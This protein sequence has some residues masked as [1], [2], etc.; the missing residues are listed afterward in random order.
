LTQSNGDFRVENIPA[1]GQYKLVISAIGFKEISRPFAFVDMK[2]VQAMRTSGQ[3]MSALLGQLDKDLGNIK[4]SIDQQILGNVTVTTNKPLVQLGIDRKI[5][6]VEKDLSAAGG[7]ATDIMRNVPSVNVD[8]DGNLTLR[9][10]T[11]QIFVDGRP[12]TLTLD[13]IP[14]DQIASVEV[15]TNP[16]AKFDASGGTAGI[17]NIVLKKARRVGYSGNVRAGIDMR[18]RVNVGGDINVRQ[19]KINVFANANFGQRK[20]ISDGTTD[21]STF[22]GN[23]TTDLH[24]VDRNINEGFFAFGRAGFDYFIDNRNTITISGV[25]VRGKF[26]GDVTSN[27]FVDT[28]FVSGDKTSF[29]NRYSTSEGIFRNLGGAVSFLHNFP[30]TGHQITAD[31][32][33]NKSRNSNENL[34]SNN[35]YAVANGPLT[36]I[37]RQFQEGRGNQQNFTVQT[38]YTNPLTATS[39]FESGLRL[40]QRKVDSRNDFRLLCIFH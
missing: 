34:V 14:A 13:Q 38:D 10:S 26:S 27:L 6:N 21:R 23:P 16:S 30:K 33:F 5:Y 11:P 3:D 1:M 4:L 39:K 32:N 37:Y 7:T 9:N 24:Q 25:A 17:L 18:G 35:I 19:G 28:N 40:T 8:I 12:T 36:S 29:T 2:Q 15:I 20:S 22:F 31:A